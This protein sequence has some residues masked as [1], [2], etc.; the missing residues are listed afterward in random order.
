M[1]TEQIIWFLSWPV[2]VWFSYQ[3]VKLALKKYEK[4]TS[5]NK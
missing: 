4:N 1:Y 2:M 5:S 3:M